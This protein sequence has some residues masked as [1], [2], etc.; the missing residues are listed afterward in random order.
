MADYPPWLTLRPI[1]L[2]PGA[3]TPPDARRRSPFSAAWPATLTLLDRELQYLHATS[4]VLEIAVR[5]HDLR[6]DGLPRAS[7]RPEHPGVILSFGSSHGPLQYPCDRFTE[8]RGNL[9]AIALGMEGLRKVDRYGITR[10]GEQYTGWRAIESATAS[11]SATDAERT[12]RRAAR[13]YPAGHTLM[14]IVRVARARTHP[15]RHRGDRT[16]Y[17]QVEAAVQ[18]LQQAGRL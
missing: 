8:W 16:A 2:W 12:I 5:E 3:S 7:A 6:L 15:D 18:V 17:D 4:P 13:P 1:T 10:R 14:Q 9:R 11:V